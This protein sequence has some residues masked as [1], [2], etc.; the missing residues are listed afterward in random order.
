MKNKKDI[1]RVIALV[2]VLL[3]LLIIP[4][5]MVGCGPAGDTIPNNDTKE[6]VKRA[7]VYLPD[8]E[9]IEG[10]Y[11]HRYTYSCG[12]VEVTIDGKSYTTHFS[13]VVVISE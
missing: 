11:T 13:N 9:I 7:I 5:M 8:G 6:T 2:T 10:E 4:L 1:I 3:M 12:A